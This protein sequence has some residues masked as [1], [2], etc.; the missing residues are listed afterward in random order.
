[1]VCCEFITATREYVP[2]DIQ[3]SKICSEHTFV[4]P[5][6]MRRVSM[7]AIATVSGSVVTS[8]SARRVPAGFERAGF[9]RAGRS[10]PRASVAPRRTRLRLTRR[11]RVVVVMLLVCAVAAAVCALALWRGPAAFGGNT[12]A[13]SGE[14]SITYVVA[15]PGDSLWSI[16]QRTHPGAD[17]RDV[18]LRIEAANGLTDEAITPGQRL[19]VP[20]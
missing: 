13:T 8:V 4:L 5:I 11:G 2:A 17:P 14:V 9:E 3:E 15:Q 1:M 19:A 18:I 16:A 10:V 20:R 7:S 6:L 12:A